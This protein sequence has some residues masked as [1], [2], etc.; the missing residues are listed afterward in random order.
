MVY[1]VLFIKEKKMLQNDHFNTVT[2]PKKI[3]QLS[4][5]LSRKLS[6]SLTNSYVRHVYIILIVTC[7]ETSHMT[8][9]IAVFVLIDIFSKQ[10]DC[11]ETN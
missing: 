9:Y 2:L 4:K 11:I 8:I 3:Y 7:A 6:V 10:S 1:S 5:K